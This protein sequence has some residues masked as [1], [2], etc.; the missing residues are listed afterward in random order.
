MWAISTT[1]ES[2]WTGTSGWTSKKRLLLHSPW[3][4]IE[5]S[6]GQEAAFVGRST[7]A[8]QFDLTRIGTH[9]K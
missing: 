4:S 6:T 3:E 8:M 2:A 1:L 7:M 9:T 5:S